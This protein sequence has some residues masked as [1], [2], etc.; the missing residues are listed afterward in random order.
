VRFQALWA[1]LVVSSINTLCIR[2]HF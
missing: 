1:I 2:L